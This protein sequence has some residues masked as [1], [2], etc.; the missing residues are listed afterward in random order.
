MPQRGRRPI[1]RDRSAGPA[2][3]VQESYPWAVCLLKARKWRLQSSALETEKVAGCSVRKVHN[4]YGDN[5]YRRYK[6]RALEEDFQ[7]V[8]AA[9]IAMPGGIVSD[10]ATFNEF[11][12]HCTTGLLRTS[13][14]E[15]TDRVVA[16]AIRT[17]RPGLGCHGQPAGNS[18][19]SQSLL[20]KG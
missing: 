16:Q 11:L 10:A 20:I 17:H 14:E 7:L 5:A 8:G 2:S 1:A 9:V 13:L 15:H 12:S 3:E 6:R 19:R 18:R 4:R